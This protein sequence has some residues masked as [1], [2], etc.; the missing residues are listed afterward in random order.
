MSNTRVGI[1]GLRYV[2][3]PLAVEFSK[4]PP[5]VDFDLK[6]S[7]SEELRPCTVYVIALPTPIDSN[8]SFNSAC[9]RRVIARKYLLL[10]GIDSFI[11][12]PFSGQGEIPYRR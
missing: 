3:L 8:N 1:V 4:K 5:T 2:G 6:A 9:N 12:R 11:V 10:P 7:R